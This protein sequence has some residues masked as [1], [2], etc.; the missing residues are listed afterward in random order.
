[1]RVNQLLNA[2]AVKIL[3]KSWL[4]NF[5]L[6]RRHTEW[7]LNQQE[8]RVFSQHR[9]DGIIEFLLDAVDDDL[10][11]FVE[12]GFAPAENNC[13]ALAIKRGF[14]GLFMDASDSGCSQARK[15]YDLL[16]LERVKTRNAFLT[17]E[18]LNELISMVGFNGEI[19]VLSIDVDGNDYWFWECLECVDPRIV[20]IEYNASFGPQATVSVPYDKSFVRYRAHESGFY[21][22]CSL[23]ALE[24]LG[25]QR[26]YRLVGVD[27]TGVNAFFVKQA[28]CI[29]VPSR[30]AEECFRDNR[31]R[32]KYKGINRDEQ[33]A[34]IKD[35]PLIDVTRD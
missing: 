20:V 27:E 18:N 30:T 31:G 32:I 10:G 21:H 33:F 35:M 5:A 14:G 16:G 17:R 25:K 2:L 19:D 7:P 28:L 29:S 26:G 11:K 34:A 9:E 15:A 6:K 12:F 1:L 22:G 23:A 3:A 8:Y 24:H 13:L 4:G